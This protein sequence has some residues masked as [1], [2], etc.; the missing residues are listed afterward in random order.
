M[1]DLPPDEFQQ[2][3]LAHGHMFIRTEVVKRPCGAKQRLVVFTCGRCGRESRNHKTKITG[4]CRVCGNV[5]YQTRRSDAEFAAKLA[6]FGHRLVR[7]FRAA[8]EYKCE[9]AC[10][11]C[12]ALARNAYQDIQTGNC[13]SC[14]PKT[15]NRAHL[16]IKRAIQDNFPALA[17][18]TP[19][20]SFLWPEHRLELD[21][22]LYQSG[23]IQCAIELDG[24]YWHAQ[25][26]VM[27]RD[28]KKMALMHRL[29]VPLLDVHLHSG[30]VIS[31]L[32]SLWPL[33]I[34]PF[35]VSHTAP[36]QEFKP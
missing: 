16:W 27:A 5:K 18:V 6:L 32:D 33:R 11:A 31:Q 21:F 12:G 4:G 22:A 36:P 35:I 20:R 19:D 1:P 30:A 15:V 28:K 23:K 2:A 14:N 10:G 13:F 29:G 24:T 26:A 3:C 9:Y 34:K 17:L 25:P 8:S 7:V